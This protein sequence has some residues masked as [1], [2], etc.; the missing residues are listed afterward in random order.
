MSPKHIAI[1]R[2]REATSTRQAAVPAIPTA[3]TK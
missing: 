3:G 2:S 1:V